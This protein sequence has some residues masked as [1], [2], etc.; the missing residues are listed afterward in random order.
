[1]YHVYMHTSVHLV[2]L[3]TAPEQKQVKGMAFP[4]VGGEA[5]LRI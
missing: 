5:S 3:A 2:I 4:L 1:M